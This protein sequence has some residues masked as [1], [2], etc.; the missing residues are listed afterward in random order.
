MFDVAAGAVEQ[1][2][3]AAKRIGPSGYL[4]AT[5]ISPASLEHAAA[6]AKE[7]GLT[8]VE[9]KV[10]DGENLDVAPESFDAVI[11]RVGLIYFPDQQK[12]LAEMMAALAPGARARWSRSRRSSRRSGVALAHEAVELGDR[13][14]LTEDRAG[15]E[16][17]PHEHRSRPICDG[18]LDA[19]P[20]RL[21]LAGARD[22]HDT[23]A[24]VTAAALRDGVSRGQRAPGDVTGDL[25][26]NELA[27][28]RLAVRAEVDPNR[29]APRLNPAFALALAPAPA[30]APAPVPAPALSFWGG[31][32]YAFE[33]SAIFQYDPIKNTT[34]AKGNAPLQVTGAGQ[35]TCVPLVAP[36]PR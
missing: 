5:D 3:T 24:G 33:N 26:V 19:Q 20:E 4:L 22:L 10:L 1:T 9:T 29:R 28:G 32:F 15:P 34:T 16:R 12:A 14:A 18:V 36:P 8:N 7:A 13:G 21:G 31:S 17:M 35:S 11:S 6:E 2:I 25:V 23:R 27:P 30:P